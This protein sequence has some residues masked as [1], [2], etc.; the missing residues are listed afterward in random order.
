MF[1]SPCNGMLAHFVMTRRPEPGS[2]EGRTSHGW[3]NRMM[4]T[5]M[6]LAVATGFSMGFALCSPALAD[7]LNAPGDYSRLAQA[8]QVQKN[9]DTIETKKELSPEEKM[10]SRFPQPARVD[11]LIGLPVLDHADSTLGYVQKVVRTADGKIKLIVPFA[12]R[13]GWI[14]DGGWFTPSRRAVA[15]PIEVVAILALQIIAIDMD[16]NAFINAPTWTAGQAET[17]SG[18]ETVKIALGR[19]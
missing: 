6:S 19:R 5:A 10:Q 16:R 15:V 11:H 4:R 8:E 3:A 9:P 1:L 17:L 2:V 12:N 13:A 14:R 18:K 7:H